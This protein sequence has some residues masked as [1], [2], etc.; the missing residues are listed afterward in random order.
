MGLR[1]ELGLRDFNDAAKP[2]GIPDP[3]PKRVKLN[4]KKREKLNRNET[5]LAVKSIYL[6]ENPQCVRCG[7]PA[8]E[9]HHVC[10]GCHRERSLL[11][12]DTW[13]GVCGTECHDLVERLSI[14]KQIHL[15]LTTT[16]RTIER[17]REL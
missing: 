17:L 16:R 1:E 3:A 13:L 2:R 11:N 4:R 6:E 8:H 12:T 14:E 5:Y 9:I 10:R 15:K 7:K